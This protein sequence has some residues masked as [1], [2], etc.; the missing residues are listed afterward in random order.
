MPF[1]TSAGIAGGFGGASTGA[2]IGAIGG[3][4]GSAIGAGIGGL[5]GLLGGGLTRNK[6]KKNGNKMQQG[7]I[8]NGFGESPNKYNQ[9][10]QQAL[11]LSL[12][13]GQELLNNPYA[14]FEPIETAARNKFQRQSIPGLAERFTALGGSDTKGSS[15]FA[16]ALGGAQSEFDQGILALRAQYG[17]QGT[18]N[19]LRM[20]QLGLDPQTEQ[21]YFGETPS[22][23]SQLFE[24]GGNLLG[25]YLGAGGDFG[26]A[27][28]RKN[29]AQKAQQAALNNKKGTF[30]KQLAMKRM[31][32]GGV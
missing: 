29:K 32:A 5:I 20:L 23:G 31:Q 2:T 12:S 17:Q 15:D 27:D 7:Q 24:Q 14:G 3:P 28:Y 25:Q 21:I 1:N 30:A 13:K 22:V 18:Q 19:A 10:Q 9:Q 6:N 4:P 11:N 16:G 26:I 8:Q